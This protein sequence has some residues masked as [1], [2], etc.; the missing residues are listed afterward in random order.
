MLN[1]YPDYEIINLDALFYA[2]RLENTED[3]KNNKRYHFIKGNIC[4]KVLVNK[5]MKGVDFVIHGAAETHVDRSIIGA[6]DFVQ[7]NVY[8]TYVLLE[9]AKIHKVERFLFTSTDE[10]YGSIEKGKFKETDNLAPNSPYSASKAGADLLCRSYFKTFNLPVL[11]TRS[12]N[13][14]GPWQFPEKLISLFVTN[15]L[16]DRKVPVYGDGKQVRDWLYVLDN[17]SGIDLVLHKGEV[18][19]VY[20]IGADCER[21][22]IEITKIILSQLGKDESWIEY[23]KDRPGHDR[24]YAL[25]SSKI[26]S[27][28]WQSQYS[29][30]Q[31]MKETINWYKENEWWWKKIKS[32][33][34][35]E[36][37]K[38]QYGK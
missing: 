37:Y 31:A 13:N 6:E 10:I 38:K 33:Q 9:A 4:D 8:G 14:Y 35:L 21:Q 20:N 1:K 28:G 11:I 17:C 19:E 15:L 27:L 24:R 25:D 16:E 23:V 30:E 22:N 34:Y 26:K 32:G 5:L 2:G 7:T 12:S 18:G 3:F 29:F 36:Y